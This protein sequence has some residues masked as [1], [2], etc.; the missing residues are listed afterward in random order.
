MKAELNLKKSDRIIKKS[1]AKSETSIYRNKEKLAVVKIH[2]DI[3]KS[4]S[5]SSSKNSLWEYPG[6]SPVIKKL[7]HEM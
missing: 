2:Q 5:Q 6:L 7:F 1:N 3:F 4:K